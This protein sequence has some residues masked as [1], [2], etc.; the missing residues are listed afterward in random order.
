MF[1]GRFRSGVDVAVKPL[2]QAL[3]RTGLSPD[4]LT[5]LGL[6]LAVPTA[7]AIATGRLGLGLGLLIGSALPDLLDGALAKAS[8]RTTVR[9]AFFDSV[10]DRVTDALVLGGIAWYLQDHHHG[11]AFMLPFAVLGVSLLISYERAKAES[12][13]FDAK[14]GLMERA[15]RIVVLCAGLAF[16]FLLVPL[17]WV[18]LALTAVTAVQRFVKVW[19]QASVDVPP[20]PPRVTRASSGARHPGEA[21][22]AMRW[23]AWR[24]ANGWTP[25]EGRYAQGSARS[26]ANQRWA[27]RRQARAAAR[28][29]DGVPRRRRS[30]SRRP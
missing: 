14:G 8:G 1:D 12:L 27:E 25:R 16:S 6:L 5:A 26:G 9:G 7:W 10:S 29:A 18:M 17:L 22:M 30:G 4:H 21:A 11:H 19:R 2:G 28:A 23:R 3:R 13:K 15:E 20:P 24:E